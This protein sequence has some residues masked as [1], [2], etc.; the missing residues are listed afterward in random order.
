MT[1][2]L[3]Q[4]G[5]LM[6]LYTPQTANIHGQRVM[7]GSRLHRRLPGEMFRNLTYW[8]LM[9]L[10]RGTHPVR[11]AASRGYLV[12]PQCRRNG[13][14]CSRPTS[15]Y[16]VRHRIALTEPRIEAIGGRI[17]PGVQQIRG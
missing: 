5:I 15:S 13:E 17:C 7:R 12:P 8:A 10:H 1:G 16:E 9:M 14:G 3:P 2:T 11:F 4:G 6:T